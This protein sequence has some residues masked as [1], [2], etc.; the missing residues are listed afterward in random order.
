MET[1][2]KCGGE[3]RDWPSISM[4]DD[5]MMICPKCYDDEYR[6]TQKEKEEKKQK[7]N[8]KVRRKM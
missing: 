3:Y 2:D 7:R 1:C 4:E 6:K 8:K 5:K